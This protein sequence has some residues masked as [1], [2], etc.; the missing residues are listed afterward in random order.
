MQGLDFSAI[1]WEDFQEL[2]AE[3]LSEVYYK[4]CKHPFT[5]YGTQGHSQEGIDVL[6]YNPDTGVHIAAE[7]KTESSVTPGLIS[8]SV[9]QFLGKKFAC[10]G[11]I[12][13]LCTSC[14]ERKPNIISRWHEEQKKLWQMGIHGILLSGQHIS[15]MLVRY[16]EIVERYWDADTAEK[17]CSEM[18]FRQKYPHRYPLQSVLVHEHTAAISDSLIRL[19][20]LLPAS[21]DKHIGGV[22]HFSR[23]DLSGNHIA[24][25]GKNMIIL[26]QEW[27]HCTALNEISRYVSDYRD[28]EKVYVQFFS[29]SFTLKSKDIPC[30]TWVLGQAWELYLHHASALANLW[31]T[32]RF[33]RLENNNKY[34][35][36]LCRVPRWFWNQIILYTQEFAYDNGS[37]ANNIF[38]PS[39]AAIHVFTPDERCN[40]DKGFHV[41][42]EA[43]PQVSLFSSDI[44]L[45]WSPI[46]SLS[47]GNMEISPRVAWDAHYTYIWL[48]EEL[49]PKVYKWVINKY[50][51]ENIVPLWHKF[52]RLRDKERLVPLE[53]CFTRMGSKGTVHPVM[54]KQDAVALVSGMQSYYSTYIRAGIER[55]LISTVIKLCKDIIGP[56]SECDERYIRNKLNL[57]NGTVYV[58]LNGL[59]ADEEEKIYPNASM[60]ELSLRV[61]KAVLEDMNDSTSGIYSLISA[62]IKP[63]YDRYIEDTLCD[64][65]Y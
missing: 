33:R 20:L 51:E 1:H 21:P 8:N 49:M 7:C 6:G 55:K 23:I 28:T 2:I 14:E 10:P 46:T 25:E 18:L 30:F 24:C 65:I 42:V 59:L 17:H 53:E 27:A 11:N 62:Q 58:D 5:V 50:Y 44:I 13:I 64:S 38:M 34:Y 39:G 12:F 37:D 22:F 32:H 15:K 35:F 26:L 52:F 40:M 31:R 56:E 43:H 41:K 45:T 9:S 61:L 3:L 54:N 19:E 60:F 63:V 47:G 16:P 36:C 4:Q 48:T 57:E 29:N